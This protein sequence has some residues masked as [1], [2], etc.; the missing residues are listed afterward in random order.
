MTESDDLLG[1][2]ARRA[3]T[4]QECEG[5]LERGR[6]KGTDAVICNDCGTPALRTW[7]P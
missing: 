3:C 5:I 4:H 2:M 1:R 6:Y 7:E